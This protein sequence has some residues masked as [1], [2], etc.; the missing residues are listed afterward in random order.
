MYKKI[1]IKKDGFLMNVIV[2]I[3]EFIISNMIFD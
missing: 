2:D 1:T 3:K